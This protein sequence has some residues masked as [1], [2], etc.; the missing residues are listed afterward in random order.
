[1]RTID[2]ITFK[3]VPALLW[4]TF[5][6]E[7]SVGTSAVIKIEL[8]SSRKKKIYNWEDLSL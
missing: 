2:A 6:S 5:S 1:M 4:G 8:T 3:I 7:K